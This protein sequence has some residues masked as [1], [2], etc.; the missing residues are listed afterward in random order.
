MLYSS[1]FQSL[2]AQGT[3]ATQIVFKVLYLTAV[4]VRDFSETLIY[5]SLLKRQMLKM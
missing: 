2:T 3:S 5:F 1:F 4:K